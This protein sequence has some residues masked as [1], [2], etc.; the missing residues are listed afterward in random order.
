MGKY[1]KDVLYVDIRSKTF[2]DKTK[3]TIRNVKPSMFEEFTYVSLAL[4]SP[5]KFEKLKVGPN[6]LIFPRD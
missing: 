3:V 4:L 1:D 2:E 5:S 6:T